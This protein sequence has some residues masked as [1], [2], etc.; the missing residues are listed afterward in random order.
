MDRKNGSEDDPHRAATQHGAASDVAAGA[1][2][3]RAI[4][5]CLK[6]RSAEEVLEQLD[7]G[8]PLGIERAAREL[9]IEQ[10]LLIDVERLV[11]RG[12]AQTAFAARLYKGWPPLPLWLHQ[13]LE[14][15]LAGLL[16]EDRERL[17]ENGPLPREDEAS[18]AFLRDAHGVAPGRA[19]A[20]AVVFNDLPP[21]VR[22]CY[23]D[24]FVLEKSI[25]GCAA[26][27]AG[28]RSEVERHLLRALTAMSTLRD[29]ARPDAG[30]SA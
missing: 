27:G 1:S 15:A 20:V 18:Y 13:C 25:E 6:G 14:R 26:S 28:S 22:R 21:I 4:P 17:L 7:A 24:V 23:Y 12:M 19:V 29:P 10:A 2:V 3:G 5:D 9:L 8:D 30:G 16:E 11:A